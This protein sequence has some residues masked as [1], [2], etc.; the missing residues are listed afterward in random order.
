MYTFSKGNIF[1]R[2]DCSRSNYG[3]WLGYSWENTLEDNIVE[4]NR[5]V[6]IAVEHGHDMSFRNNTVRLNGE[7]IRLWTRGG[8][9]LKYW[10]GFEVSYNFTIEDN[11]IE[12]NNIGFAGYAGDESPQECHGFTL[13]GNTFRD[14]RV[15]AYFTRVHQC[16][17]NDNTFTG[18]VVSAIRL[19]NQPDVAVE[20]NR[21][22]G[23]V[24]EM[25]TE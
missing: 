8:A 24:R 23:N 21:F 15:G 14:N 7:G 16:C 12:S 1:R 17:V 13:H 6:G 25:A 5:W 22:D 9:T 19:L 10:P 18:N 4:F 20:N 3:F 2:N 11:L